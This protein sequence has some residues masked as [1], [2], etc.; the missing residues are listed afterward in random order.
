MSESGARGD[1]EPMR[2]AFSSDKL[3]VV[4]ALSLGVAVSLSLLADPVVRSIGL[5]E[6]GLALGVVVA[7]TGALAHAVMTPERMIGA[8]R[9]SLVML[10]MAASFLLSALIGCVHGDSPASVIRSTTPYLMAFL[11][12]PLA[13]TG[14]LK[15]NT[16]GLILTVMV[17]GFTQA[18]YEIS[19]F[20][21]QG[22]STVTQTLVSRITMI[23][24]RVTLPLAAAGNGVALALIGRGRWAT[25]VGVVATA[26]FGLAALVT[27]TRTLVIVHGLTV[28][29]AMALWSSLALV[30]RRPGVLVRNTGW[31]SLSMAMLWVV[32]M[33]PAFTT[34]PQAFQVRQAMETEKPHDMRQAPETGK[35][36]TSEDEPE[37]RRI[38]GLLKAKVGQE[39]ASR[40]LGN[41]K[42]VH[43]AMVAILR[44]HGIKVLEDIV[45]Q[46]AE[47]GGKGTSSK[48]LADILVNF[49]ATVPGSS[50]LGGGRISDEWLPA[51]HTYLAGNPATW[52]FGI[53]AGTP[54]MTRSG[55][56]RTYIHNLPLYLLLYNGA[57][58]LVLYILLQVGLVL[59]FF[60]RVVRDNDAVAFSCL[61]ILVTLNCFALLFAVHKLIG[62]NLV[63]AIVY[64]CFLAPRPVGHVNT[65]ALPQAAAARS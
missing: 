55:E 11:A 30:Q 53:G 35:S 45:Q 19:L 61:S 31:L 16:T 39:P 26:I 52:T 60:R 58:G 54:F 59:S 49:S 64:S 1:M 42:S 32:I 62:F 48:I 5:M 13:I 63:L 3:L 24:A 8:P 21:M 27:L 7:G 36:E 20:L 33:L 12:L 57:V 6:M 41:A 28:L 17:V 43:E 37:I 2:A 50:E 22:S 44:N 47:L 38:E 65:C 4:F 25:M 51:F 23:D 15:L 29:V 34:V 18:V 10:A 56:P 40:T 46:Y 9:T 14:R